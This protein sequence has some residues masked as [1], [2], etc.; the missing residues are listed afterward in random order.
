MIRSIGKSWALIFAL[1]STLVSL[2]YT[3]TTVKNRSEAQQA[4]LADHENRLKDHE[5]RIIRV[6]D[7]ISATKSNTDRLVD[8]LL[9]K[10]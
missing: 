7:A 1:I 6:E 10:K 4:E 5:T 3:A 8:E 2:V 9:D